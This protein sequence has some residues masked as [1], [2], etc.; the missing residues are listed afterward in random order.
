MKNVNAL[1]RN[2]LNKRYDVIKDLGIHVKS[3]Y[4]LDHG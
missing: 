2:K 1:T 3:A 4:M